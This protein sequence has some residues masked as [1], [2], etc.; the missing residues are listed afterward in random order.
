MAEGRER[1]ATRA[2]S[3]HRAVSDSA[4]S[5]GVRSEPADSGNFAVVVLDEPA[6]SLLAPDLPVGESQ[7]AGLLEIGVGQ[8]HDADTLMGSEL[9]LEVLSFALGC[10][11]DCTVSFAD[12]AL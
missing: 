6:E 9:C 3:A 5:L 10:L 1:L 11:P 12:T 2:A 7:D 8:R 4:M